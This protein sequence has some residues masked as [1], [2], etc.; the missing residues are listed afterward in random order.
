MSRGDAAESGSSVTPRKR[1]AEDFI[2]P[3]YGNFQRYYHIR[4]PNTADQDAWIPGS[5]AHPAL[6]VDGRVTSILTYLCSYFAVTDEASKRIYPSEQ[7]EVLDI[8]CNSGKLT[9][10]LAQTLPGL[11]RECR[12]GGQNPDSRYEDRVMSKGD[13]RI[14]GVDIDA[15]LI[16]QAKMAA[17]AARSRYRPEHIRNAGDRNLDDTS[18]RNALPPKACH[19]PSVFPTLYGSIP[20]TANKE[21]SLCAEHHSHDAHLCP[22]YLDFHALEWVS[23]SSPQ[24]VPSSHPIHDTSPDRGYTIILALSITKWIHIQQ[25]DLG[26]IRFFARISS[27]LRP[28]GLLFLERQQWP[29]YHSARNMDS[30]MKGKIRQLQLR[31]DGDFDWWLETMGVELVDV[32]GHGTG[33]GFERPLQVFRKTEGSKEAELVERVLNEGLEPV[34]WVARSRSSRSAGG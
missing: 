17:A 15:S 4:N 20:S 14:V 31:P 7:V 19:F 22:P 27:S 32:I 11:L 28:G 25:S 9:I 23:S 12:A 2:K 5:S 30:T 29:S 10:E 24:P 13:V 26:L 18:D 34:A 1:P 16:R 21:G 3:I 6:A 8:G 33:V